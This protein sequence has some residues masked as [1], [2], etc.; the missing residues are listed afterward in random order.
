MLKFFSR[1][2][3]LFARFSLFDTLADIWSF[4]R[5]FLQLFLCGHFGGYA[6]LFCK[7]VQSFVVFAYRS[8]VLF[9]L[10]NIQLV[11]CNEVI[12]NA[13]CALVKVVVNPLLK[14][15]R[16]LTA[17][18]VESTVG[19]FVGGNVVGQVIE[20]ISKRLPS[21]VLHVVLSR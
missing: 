21:G 8:V 2:V 9:G 4:A 7:A 11:D 19:R 1:C 6:F 12:E 10:S 3:F 5:S 14:R 18:A 16:I 15:R 17:F 20:C 13:D